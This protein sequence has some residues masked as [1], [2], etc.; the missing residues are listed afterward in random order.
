MRGHKTCFA[1]PLTKRTQE[2]ASHEL[3]VEYVFILRFVASPAYKAS[4]P[5][6]LQESKISV[7]ICLQSQCV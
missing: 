2:F 7:T 6:Q 5:C 4:S 3:K 1:L